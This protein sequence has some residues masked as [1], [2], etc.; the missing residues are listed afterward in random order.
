MH[1]AGVVA[2]THL[3]YSDKYFYDHLSKNATGVLHEGVDKF[4]EA[5]SF[6]PPVGI[7][8]GTLLQALVYLAAAL[9]VFHLAR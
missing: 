6:F 1:V 8:V 9:Y 3:V 2:V 7:T 5:L 4:A